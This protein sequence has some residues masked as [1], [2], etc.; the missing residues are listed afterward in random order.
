MKQ[1]ISKKQWDEITDEQK[2]IIKKF[3]KNKTHSISL[4]E[5][6]FIL[7]IGQMI[8]FLGNNWKWDINLMDDKIDNDNLCDALWESVKIKLKS[9]G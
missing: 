7:D 5:D 6:Y 4:D 8:E 9:D 1:Q 3:F 2:A